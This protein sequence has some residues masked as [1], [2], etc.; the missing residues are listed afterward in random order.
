[1]KNLKTM[2]KWKYKLIDSLIKRN[3]IRVMN[4]DI[5]YLMP[6]KCPHCGGDVSVL[7]ISA[8]WRQQSRVLPSYFVRCNDPAC[9]THS[10][11]YDTAINTVLDWNER[12]RESDY[13]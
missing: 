3:I 13:E 11:L 6:D 1:M 4:I 10:R 12:G 9:R 5:D 7:R 2:S 8:F